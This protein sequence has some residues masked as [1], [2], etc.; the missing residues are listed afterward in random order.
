VTPTGPV[1]S[2]TYRVC[3]GDTLHITVEGEELFTR[4][5][6]VNAA[7]TISYPMLGDVAA[8]G[9]TCGELR[10]QLETGLKRYLT[11]PRVMVTIQQYG[12]MGQSVYVMGEVQSPDVYPFARGT[13]VMQPIAAACGLT[14]FATGRISVIQGRTGKTVS[15]FLE[16]IV[17]QGTAG[18]LEP[19]DVIVVERKEEA[20]YAVLGEVP[21]PGMFEMPIRG[22]VRVLDA[23]A[24]SGLLAPDVDE[25]GG[26]EEDPIDD[27]LRIADLEHAKVTRG[28]T[29]LAVNLVALLQGDTSQN[30]VLQAGD[31]LTVPRRAA[32]QVYALGE[33]RSAGRLHLPEDSTVLDLIGAA[34][35]ITAGAD[36]TEGS[37]L[38]MVEGT[39]TSI[40]VDL[41]GLLTKGDVEQNIALQE[42]DVLFVPARGERNRDV[43][44][45]LTL[46]PYLLL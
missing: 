38:R 16:D 13:G 22:E 17:K 46:M 6:Q 31:V 11:H 20:R 39:P 35:G 25:P 29:E 15:A 42:G 8:A 5:C 14:E 23:M 7:G 28:E 24:A 33:V 10:E 18:L 21:N 37:L 34:D 41:G 3:P 44:R 9:V 26:E 36:V 1:G 4:A 40:P 12:E 43:W 32:I 45:L 27:P 19:G 2:E 30:L